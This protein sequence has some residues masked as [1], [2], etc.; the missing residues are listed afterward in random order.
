MMDPNY[1]FGF[2]A[3]VDRRGSPHSEPGFGSFHSVRPDSASEGGGFCIHC[4]FPLLRV[5]SSLIFR[6]VV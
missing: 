6:A 3:Y 5:L 4:G 2:A 1:Y